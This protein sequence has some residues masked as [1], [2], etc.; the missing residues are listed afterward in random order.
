MYIIKQFPEDF[1]VKEI[2]DLNGRL[3]EKGRF[4]YLNLIKRDY[5]TMKA[6]QIIA[7]KLN[8]DVRKIGFAG[9]K[10][11]RAVTEQTISVLCDKNKVAK[12]KI[13]DIKLE[14]LGYGDEPIS[15]GEH[16]G[17]EFMITVRNFKSKP[18]MMCIEFFPNFFD[19]QR[20][21][22]N[23]GQVGRLIITNKFKKAIELLRDKSLDVDLNTRIKEFLSKQS[24]NYIGALRLIPKKLLR[25]YVHSYQSYL[26]NKVAEILLRKSKKNIELPVIG[27]ATEFKNKM[28]K[29]VYDKILANEN[30]ISRDFILKQ[31][32]ELSSS[33]T[34]RNLFAKIYNL[35]ILKISRDELNKNKYKIKIIFSLDKGCYATT[36]LK[37]LFP[38]EGGGQYQKIL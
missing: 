33:G 20:F 26:W 8:T 27:F 37:Y 21:S 12:I 36:A 16:K 17:N 5:T 31:M 15:L 2:F 11:R 9:N 32:P 34:E 25:L 38:Y 18:K 14:F 22:R 3:K 1:I 10:D 13:K 24:G 30:I 29:K 35:K 23:N 7:E 4:S 28:V 19:G 6:V